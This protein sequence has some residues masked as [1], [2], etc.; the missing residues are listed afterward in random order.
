MDAVVSQAHTMSRDSKYITDCVSDDLPF[1]E[2]KSSFESKESDFKELNEVPD[3]YNSSLDGVK[4]H[5]SIQT[6]YL[7]LG[8]SLPMKAVRQNVRDG[9]LPNVS[10]KSPDCDVFFKGKLR[11][12]IAG[13]L[14]KA[15]DIGTLHMNTKEKVATEFVDSPNY[16][17]TIVEEYYIFVYVRPIRS[18][19]AATGEV[20]RF[21]KSF[22]K[23][24]GYT[25]YRIQTD[26]KL[27]SVV[28]L[29]IWR[30]KDLIF[31]S[32]LYIRP[33]RVA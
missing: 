6:W 16:F 24:T 1:M 8:H 27:N 17:V 23:Q 21:T 25:V 29:T 30:T 19:A 10:C 9:R 7:R 5:K 12:R 2:N 33:S 3:L 14:T 15:G 18:Q 20:F 26:W 31:H 4:I 32:L 28:R 22:E 13:S 11:R